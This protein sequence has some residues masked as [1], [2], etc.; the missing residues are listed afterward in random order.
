MVLYKL[1]ELGNEFQL[2]FCVEKMYKKQ[3]NYENTNRILFNGIGKY[4]IPC[5][6]AQEFEQCEM[7]GFNE[8]LTCAHPE[9][10]CVHFYLDDYQFIRIWNN[11]DR[12]IPVLQRFK[13]VCA[14]DFSLYTDF[15]VAI[16]IYNHYRKHW[17][18]AYMIE[19]GIKVI[20]TIC[21]SDT[22]S[23]EWCFDGEP[24]DSCVTVSS[25]GTQSNS[26]SKQMFADGYNTMMKR[27]RPSKVIFYGN[28]P[29]DC[30]GNIVHIH[31]FQE[32]WNK[33]EVAQW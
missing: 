20:P 23:F 29:N 9:D 18:A 14:P 8:A 3:R 2:S 12:Y 1:R 5:I 16:Q 19:H 7:I 17:I 26:Q 31:S 13:Y 11:I 33:A 4:D 21:W 15:P 30:A 32:K 22:R 24:I 28:V 6:R 25:I 10:K 27:L